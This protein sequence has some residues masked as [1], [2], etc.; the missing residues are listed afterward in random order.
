MAFDEFSDQHT[1]D[2]TMTFIYSLTCDC[3]TKQVETIDEPYHNYK[4]DKCP[5]C[6]KIIIVKNTEEK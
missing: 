3:G 5:D 1:E 2:M 4:D 6:G